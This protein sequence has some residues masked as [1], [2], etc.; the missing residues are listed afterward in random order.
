MANEAI[1]E[2]IFKA[3]LDQKGYTDANQII[4][5]RQQST[6]TKI[7]NLLSK[8]SKSSKGTGSGYPD[9]IIRTAKYPQLLIVVECKAETKYHESE[10]KI[11]Y[12]NY[13]VDGALLYASFLAKEYDV[14]AIGV[15]GQTKQELR[16]SS[17]LHLHG[18]DKAH[19][20]FG[21]NLLKLDEYHEGYMKSDLK[22]NQDYDALLAYSKHLNDLLQNKKIKESQRSLL[23]SAI[24]IALD[25]KAFRLG[26]KELKTAKEITGHIAGTVRSELEGS[27]IPP[28]KIANILHAY[29]FIEINASLTGNK[30][31]IL[32]LID[33]IDKNINGFIKTHQ[34]FDALGQF[35]I[36][37]LRYANADKGLGIVLTPPHITQLF[38]ELADID[39]DSV[40][41]DNCCG[42]GGFLIS[43]MRKMILDAKG[44]KQREESIKKNQL[45]GIEFQDDIYAL[46]ASN[47]ILHGDGKSNIFQGDCFKSVEV[48]RQRFKPTVA[49]LTPPYKS[50]K[51]DPEELAFALNALEMLEK[52]GKCAIILPMSCALAQKG[53]EAELKR[54]LLEHHTL[55]AVLSL[56]NDLFHNSKVNVVTCI[57]IFTSHKPHPADKETWFGYWKDD[58]LVKVKNRGRVDLNHKWEKIKADWLS[59]YRNRKSLPGYSVARV[60]SHT[61][62][63]CAE[64]YMETDYSK[65][66]NK[67]FENVVRDYVGFNIKIGNLNEN[68]ISISEKKEFNVDVK[69]WRSFKVGETFQIENTKGTTTDELIEGDAIPYIAAKKD[70]NGLD[71]MCTKDGNEP[72]ISKG[73]CIVF[74][75]L[76]QG[77]A[78]YTTYQERD[79]I[80]MSGKTS[81]GY[82]KNLNK[83]T[84]LFLVAVLDLER[85]KFSF[86]R[87][88]TGI[89]LRET[90][91]KLPATKINGEYVPDW[92]LMEAYIQSLPYSDLI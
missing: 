39:K 52:S 76:G 73:N 29:S 68:A 83:Y 36:E 43:A 58:G 49:L 81:C 34:Y 56:P 79:F 64:A 19:P 38:V 18:Q 16:L 40:V 41:L 4:V 31:F 53:D 5:E 8:A 85:P 14:I 59:A 77:S 50:H 69:N 45:V 66:T 67:D 88:W 26:F 63:W 65:L 27:D 90:S 15:S 46:A 25:N 78:G 13:A 17:Y 32:K 47:M 30:D 3:L 44:N 22:F 1:T 48:V 54:R 6:N 74:I 87:S 42:T 9:F 20:V 35:Y 57:M 84:G 62:E 23:I 33:G 24:L 37:F 51:N 10:T 11:N 7:Q 55:E 21:S 72:F 91:I 80:G 71:M 60:V 89:R 92:L 2:D 61:D 86:G 28:E 75:Q 12:A 82:N 70:G